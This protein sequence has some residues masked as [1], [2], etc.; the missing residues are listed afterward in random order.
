MRALLITAGIFLLSLSLRA[1]QRVAVLAD[2]D[3]IYTSP[4]EVMPEYKGG[5]DGLYFRLNHIR[6]LFAERMKQIQGKRQRPEPAR[7]HRVHRR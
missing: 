3:K 7:A 5:E 2:D 6:Y 1:Q 4:V